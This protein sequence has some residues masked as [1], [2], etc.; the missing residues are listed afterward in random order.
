MSYATDATTH[1]AF[2]AAARQA[3]VSV[4]YFVNRTGVRSGGT[5][6][7]I[8]SAGLA[9]PTVDV[10]MASLAMHSAREL[11]SAADPE[12]LIAALTAFLRPV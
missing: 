6:G 2:L 5:I 3:D 11:C 8:V 9:M 12:L 7:P 4:Q 1:A 10:G